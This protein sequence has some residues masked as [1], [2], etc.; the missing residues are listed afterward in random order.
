MDTRQ[1]I[2]E[3]M[4]SDDGVFSELQGKLEALC[5]EFGLDPEKYSF[6]ITVNEEAEDDN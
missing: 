5:E 3:A 6:Y 4:N 1:E 2:E